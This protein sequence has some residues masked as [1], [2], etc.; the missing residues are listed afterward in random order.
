MVSGRKNVSIDDIVTMATP[1][2]YSLVCIVCSLCSLS[3]CVYVCVIAVAD[4]SADALS[5]CNRK[6]SVF[7]P[8]HN[9]EFRIQGP[10]GLVRILCALF[11]FFFTP[12]RCNSSAGCC[13]L[14]AFH[15]HTRRREFAPNL[16]S[17]F[18]LFAILNL[19]IILDFMKVE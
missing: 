3:V 11:R 6:F 4:A 17:L 9:F 19:A 13:R 10:Q 1:A 5:T 16:F 12:L 2:G 18:V 7:S 8:N 15:T 14:S